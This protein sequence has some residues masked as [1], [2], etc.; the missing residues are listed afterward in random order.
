MISVDEAL[1]VGRVI[2]SA[3][4]EAAGQGLWD[5]Y[6]KLNGCKTGE[7]KVTLGYK[8]PA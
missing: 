4:Y 2:D 5:D 1:I 6:K 7:Y 8:L 3:I